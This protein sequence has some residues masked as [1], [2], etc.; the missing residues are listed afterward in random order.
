MN[1]DKDDFVMNEDIKGNINQSQDQSHKDNKPLIF[2]GA[3]DVDQSNEAGIKK[4][5]KQTKWRFL[6]LFFACCFLLGSYF[7]YDNPGV[8]EKQVK[9]NDFIDMT[10][11][12]YNL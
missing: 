10:S 7:C 3:T 11:A 2:E 12:E 4:S 8:I 5:F 6:M 9:E 1:Q